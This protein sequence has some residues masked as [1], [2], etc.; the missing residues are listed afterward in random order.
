[1]RVT[2][3]VWLTRAV[4]THLLQEICFVRTL[5]VTPYLRISIEPVSVKTRL[6]D[7]TFEVFFVS[8]CKVDTFLILVLQT[9]LNNTHS[10]LYKTHINTP[11]LKLLINAIQ[12]HLVFPKVEHGRCRTT[13]TGFCW[14]TRKQFPDQQ[15]EWLVS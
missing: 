11:Y 13:Y 6:I 15:G 12:W 8:F 2:H 10:F 5:H 9:V 3:M 1:M 14:P 4:Y 7:K